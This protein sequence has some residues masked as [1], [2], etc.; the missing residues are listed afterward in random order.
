[1]GV[2]AFSCQIVQTQ[3]LALLLRAETFWIFEIMFLVSELRFSSGS[4][5]RSELESGLG[6][7]SVSGSVS[8]SCLNLKKQKHGLQTWRRACLHQHNHPLILLSICSFSP[9]A[10]SPLGPFVAVGG[11][12]K[13]Q[14]HR[15]FSTKMMFYSVWYTDFKT[16]EKIRF[17]HRDHLP[18]I[19]HFFAQC[20][21][22]ILKDFFLIL[23]L[24]FSYDTENSSLFWNQFWKAGD[25]EISEHFFKWMQC[26]L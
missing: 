14:L 5:S 17:V 2:L 9:P 13:R 21:I 19:F 15:I 11:D 12:W 4:G 1:M 18:P 20:Y 24:T 6:S 25:L 23:N 8:G 10:K 26:Y 16:V 7:L 3:Y 22:K